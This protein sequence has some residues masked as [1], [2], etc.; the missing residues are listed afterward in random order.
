MDKAGRSGC[1]YTKLASL[2]G[3]QWSEQGCLLGESKL[4]RGMG[5]QKA[6]HENGQLQMEV[7]TVRGEFC[8]RNRIWLRDGTLLSECFY[9]HGRIVRA[10]E[11]RDAMTTN[12]T[13]P[14]FRGAP[15]KIPPKNDATQRH[16]YRAFIGSLLE[17][18]KHSEAKGVAAREWRRNNRTFARTLQTRA[19]RREVR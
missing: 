3:R 12:K 10:D 2:M 17:K 4:T 14:T 9:L 7:S 19:R 18:P 6:W 1:G 13:L 5:I 11:Y 15:A 16:I 8:G